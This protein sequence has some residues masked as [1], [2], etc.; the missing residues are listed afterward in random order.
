MISI[1]VP[2]SMFLEDDSLGRKTTKVGQLA[3]SAAIFGVERIYIYRD[4]S[5]DYEGDY[6]VAKTIFE[7]AETP[8]YLRKRLFGRRKELD[9]AG[10]LPPLRTPHHLVEPMPM[11]GEVR[12]AVVLLQNGELVADV[13][14]RE[15][16]RFEGRAHEGQ[17]TTVEVISV[18]PLAV[19]SCVKPEGKYWGYEVRRAPSLARFLRSANFDMTIL[20]SR[21]GAPIWESWEEFRGMTKESGKI[22]MCYGSPV[23]GVNE[24]LAQDKVK[25]SDF[26][27]AQY[28]NFF[29][30]QNAETIRLEEAILGSL[31][32]LNLFVH[33]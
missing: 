28:L 27:K 33:L 13:G 23:S 3:R 24:M 6:L 2:D 31:S 26:P 21:L 32:I 17:R 18:K 25:V 4:S 10:L 14:S 29:P 30:F 15:L 7:Y 1:A 16:A 9:F 5:H 11:K 22:L 12:E 8:Q 19:K 20:T